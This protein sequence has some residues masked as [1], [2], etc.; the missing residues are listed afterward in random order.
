MNEIDPILAV[1]GLG[2]ARLLLFQDSLR[3]ERRGW[4]T[5]LF[6]GAVGDKEIQLS[7]IDAIQLKKDSFL[8]QSIRFYFV[9]SLENKGVLV[10][11]RDENGFRFKSKQQ[12]VFEEIKAAIENR[13]NNNHSEQSTAR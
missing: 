10:H 1:R 13:K 8:Y 4:R 9:N 7:S 5:F 11:F 3:I 6:Q 2:G 12:P